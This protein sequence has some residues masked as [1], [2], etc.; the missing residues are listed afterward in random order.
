[1]ESAALPPRLIGYGEMIVQPHTICLNKNKP[2]G[3][4]IPGRKEEARLD[5]GQIAGCHQGWA[6]MS[7]EKLVRSQSVEVI[8]HRKS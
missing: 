6:W 3:G 4:N 5:G 1:M 8:V 2:K 7:T